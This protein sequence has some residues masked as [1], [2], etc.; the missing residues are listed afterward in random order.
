VGRKSLIRPSRASHTPKIDGI[1]MLVTR[2]NFEAD[3]ISSVNVDMYLEGLE[4]RA[5]VICR[6]DILDMLVDV[7]LPSEVPCTIVMDMCK[8]K[9]DLADFKRYESV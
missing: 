1:K 4:P 2:T 5:E 9:L 3:A 6:I 8:T 7:S